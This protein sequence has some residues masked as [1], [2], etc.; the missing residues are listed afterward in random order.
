V[1]P[2]LSVV[3]PVYNEAPHLRRTVDHLVAAVERSGFDADVVLVD[4]GSTDGSAEAA[5]SALADR[6]PLSVVR[7]P[8]RGRFHAVREGLR[9][10]RGKDVLVLGARVRLRPDSL[11]FVRGRQEAG[12][13]V[14]TGHVH[15]HTDGNP[16]GT[17]MNVITEIAWREYF[18][19]PR[20]A[21]FGLAEF[22]RYPKGSGCFVAPREVLVAAFDEI[23]ARYADVR[24]ANDDAPMLRRIAASTPIHV[25][26]AFAADYVPRGSFRTFLKHSLHRGS[27]F[28]DGHGR[29]ES[30]F[31]PIIVAFYPASAALI[32]ASVLR[33]RVVPVA[34]LVTSG[35]AAS[36]ALS[37]GRSRSEVGT[38]AA[39][40]P[41]WAVALGAGLWRGLGMLAAARVRRAERRWT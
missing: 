33:P 40:A 14:W 30:R 18:D 10:A 25:S 38:V 16:Y 17:F 3:I 28:L 5:A 12:E 20:T 41:V 24:H 8:N 29:R 35:G 7:Q 6:L 13:P 32:V 9:Q 26:P 4:D 27:V 1:N 11:V 19:R 31:F 21:S 15:I 34:L 37:A 22:D 39:L 2:T 23:P 36:V